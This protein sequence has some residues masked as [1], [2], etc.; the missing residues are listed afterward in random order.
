M[1]LISATLL[2]LASDIPGNDGFMF[3]QRYV[4]LMK[5]SQADLTSANAAPQKCQMQCQN[6]LKR[7]VSGMRDILKKLKV[8]NHP[9]VV[10]AFA[11]VDAYEKQV[12]AIASGTATATAPAPVDPNAPPLSSTAAFKLTRV[13]Q[14][15]DSFNKKLAASTVE[16]FAQPGSVSDRYYRDGAKQMRD[17][18]KE[19]TAQ[20]HPSVLAMYAD[21]EAYEAA[22]EAK[23]ADGL[24]LREANKAAAEAEAKEVGSELDELATYF[25]QGTFTARLAPPF[26]EERTRAWIENLKQWDA[27][28]AK[29]AATLD[30]LATEHPAFVNDPKMKSLRWWF[31]DSNGLKAFLKS[32]IGHTAETWSESSNSGNGEMRGRVE[33]VQRYMGPGGFAD[34]RYND[35]VQFPVDMKMIQDGVEAAA[36]LVIYAKEYKHEGVAEAEKTAADVRA[37]QS[38]VEARG[39]ALIAKNRFPAASTSDPNLLGIA[40][41]ILPDCGAGKV[42]RLVINYGPAH[43][44]GRMSSS[45]DEGQWIRITSWNEAWDEFQVVAAEPEGNDYRLVY[46]DL[47]HRSLGPSWT[48]TNRWYCSGRIPSGRILKENINK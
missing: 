47:K 44:T 29:G 39:K 31:T 17:L 14:D 3:D 32:G 16:E 45:R 9:L 11:D 22:T 20:Q 40:R 6:D 38:R 24:K 35:D 23:I 36:A 37:F 27:A 48:V 25:N 34:S 2:I 13:R 12:L 21:I 28:A 4:P 33:I 1:V 43:K 41:K 8:P 5:R 15:Y 18:L 19:V 42:E 26:T 46:Y 7:N 30:K 10:Q